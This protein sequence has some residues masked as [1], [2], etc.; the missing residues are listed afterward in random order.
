MRLHN[1]IALVLLTFISFNG[2][3]QNATAEEYIVRYDEKCIATEVKACF[4][5]LVGD[6]PL[7]VAKEGAFGICRDGYVGVGAS[8]VHSEY[9][10]NNHTLYKAVFGSPAQEIGS[11]P[12][13]FE[14]CRAIVDSNRPPACER[15]ELTEAGWRNV[16]Q[17]Q[18]ATIALELQ[19]ACVAAGKKPEDCARPSSALPF[20]PPTD[21]K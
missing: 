6:V 16:L 12:G 18:F 2:R 21:K 10:M 19:R 7:T 11:R 20:P 4:V 1:L 13:A 3:A 8:C 17:A 15:K 9:A 5:K 14:I